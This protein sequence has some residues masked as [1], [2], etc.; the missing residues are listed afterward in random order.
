MNKKT[1][2][3][4]ILISVA[5][6]IGVSRS[7]ATGFAEPEEQPAQAPIGTAFTYQGQLVDNGSPASGSYDFQFQLFDALSSGSQAGG[8]VTKDDVSVSDG[9]FTVELDFGN[10][11]NGSALWLDIGVRDGASTGAFTS[12]SPRQPLTP[13]PYSISTLNLPSHDHWGGS[14]T[15]SGTGL[16]L[17]STDSSGFVNGIWAEAASSD[18]NG[19]YG[20]ATSLTGP[21]WGIVGESDSNEGIGVYG[22][23]SSLT[24]LTYGVEGDTASSTDFVAGV[25]GYASATDGNT[26]GVLGVS[27]SPLGEGVFG[28]ATSSTGITTGVYGRSDSD[29]GAGV[30]G[31]ASSTTGA[32]SGVVGFADSSSDYSTGVYGNSSASSGY[33]SGVMGDTGSPG[34]VGVIGYNYASSGMA[35]GVQGQSDS[36][37]GVGVWGYASSTA[38]SDVPVGVLGEAPSATGW[39]VYSIGD[40]GSSGL[41]L[42]VVETQDNG[43]RR[44]YAVESPEVWFEDFGTGQLID[45]SATIDIEKIYSQTVNLSEDYH[46]FLTPLGDCQ[47]YVSDKGQSSFTVQAIGGQ[48]CNIDFDYRITAKRLGYEEM[49]LDSETP[50]TP[51]LIS[52]DVI[53]I[54]QVNPRTFA[55]ED[56]KLPAGK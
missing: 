10:V 33:T 40:M 30:V 3:L 5:L 27:D 12:L 22:G 56:F 32:T 21:A 42:A 37:D 14:W 16:S 7:F 20:Y 31:W 35:I 18:G 23:A 52:V 39:G 41:K 6:L 49:R 26:R 50:P 47:L 48:T 13:V 44:L 25:V 24:G 9:K 51:S 53:G 17:A 19:V 2:A 15:G 43:W 45:G 1:Y 34:G 54:S 11:F 55:G 46:L 38:T 4:A 36:P 29:E 28:S 8:T